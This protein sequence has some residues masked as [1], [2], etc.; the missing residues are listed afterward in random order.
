MLRHAH[1]APPDPIAVLVLVEGDALHEPET[2]VH[3]GASGTKHP[4]VIL[5]AALLARGAP[6]AIPIEA[7]GG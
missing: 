6:V 3:R 4:V 7:P 2:D 1:T 5:V